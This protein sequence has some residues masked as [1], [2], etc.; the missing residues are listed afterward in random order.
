MTKQDVGMYDVS[1]Q[2]KMDMF[3]AEDDIEM[4]DLS[5]D[6]YAHVNVIDENL[7]TDIVMEDIVSSKNK[8]KN[9]ALVMLSA[10]IL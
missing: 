10:V 7:L 9:P 1:D 3:I 2:F 8:I 4:T 6:Y 5:D